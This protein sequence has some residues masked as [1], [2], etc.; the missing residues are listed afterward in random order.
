MRLALQFGCTLDELGWRMTADE[1]GLWA[2]LWSEEPWG[3]WRADYRAGAVAATVVNM[4]GRTRAD[5]APHAQPA[6][7]MPFMRDRK[8]EDAEPEPDPREFFRKLKGPNG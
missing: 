4:A 2:A 8:S 6:D 1:F 7:F 5:T 3:D